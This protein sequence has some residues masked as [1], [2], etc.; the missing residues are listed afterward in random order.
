M[1]L[2]LKDRSNARQYVRQ[3]VNTSLL[4]CT[5]VRTSV[6]LLCEFEQ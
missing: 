6:G 1:R 2:V 5:S 3:H 4:K